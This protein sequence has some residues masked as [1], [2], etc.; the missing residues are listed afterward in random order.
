ME[1]ARSGQ[2]APDTVTYLW[3]HFKVKSHF[4]KQ[5]GKSQFA[6]Y[7]CVNS[8]L[9]TRVVDHCLIFREIW[10]FHQLHSTIVPLNVEH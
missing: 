7:D 2:W 1:V 4:C 10:I 6:A 3:A 9:F 8:G 5:L